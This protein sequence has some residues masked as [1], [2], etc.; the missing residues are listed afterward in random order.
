[1]VSAQAPI[2]LRTADT[3]VV[4][5]DSVRLGHRAGKRIA[6][7][8]ITPTG[9]SFSVRVRRTAQPL[10]DST[11]VKARLLVLSDIEGGFERFRTLMLRHRV[12]GSQFRWIFGPNHLVIVGDHVD[13]GRNVLEFL[14]LLYKI[15]ADAERAGG[16]VHVLL[17]NHE[18]MNIQGDLRYV[19]Q[20]S[21][22]GVLQRTKSIK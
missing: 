13:R 20:Q 22:A 5:T 15:E 17:G 6:L 12:L 11:C 4:V 18:I 21:G 10:P 1:M 8:V 16:R 19:H 14:W 9:D 2:V 3:I 7:T